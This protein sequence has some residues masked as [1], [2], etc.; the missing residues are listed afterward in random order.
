MAPSPV[1][2]ARVAHALVTQRETR[3]KLKQLRPIEPQIPRANRAR[4]AIIERRHSSAHTSA[5]LLHIFPAH[6]HDA[7]TRGGDKKPVGDRDS[8]NE[9]APWSCDP[10]IH[11]SAC[12][13]VRRCPAPSAA[14][15]CSLPNGA[16]ISTTATS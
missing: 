6:S 12:K 9:E 10:G 5:P 11:N 15:R 14:I 3:E 7:V 1:R 13:S 16:S 8:D 4:G 2:C